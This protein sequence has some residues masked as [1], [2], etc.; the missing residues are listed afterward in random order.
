MSFSI[1]AY[2]VIIPFNTHI[3]TTPTVLHANFPL[4][5]TGLEIFSYGVLHD[6]CR[7]LFL[8]LNGLKSSF[9][10]ADLILVAD[11]SHMVPDQ[12]NKVDGLTLS[13]D[14][15]LESS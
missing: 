15:W 8:S 4:S 3:S 6:V 10:N 9:F 13:S 1:Y 5:E 14:I 2:L 12:A 7:F 11:K